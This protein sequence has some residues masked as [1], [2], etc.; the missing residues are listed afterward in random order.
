MPSQI[1]AWLNERLLHTLQHHTPPQ[2]RGL[3]PN[4]LA[5]VISRSAPTLPQS[6]QVGNLTAEGF[7]ALGQ[8]FTPQEA[9]NI[10]AYFLAR[11]C[12]NAHV[13]SK[14]DRVPRSVDETAERFHYGVYP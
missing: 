13:F 3:A 12:F 5:Q 7:Q 1:D 11:P 2:S 8:I 4:I 14:S 9:A 10:R 6:D